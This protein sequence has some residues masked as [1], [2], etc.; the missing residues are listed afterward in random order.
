MNIDYKTIKY[1][2]LQTML[3]NGLDTSKLEQTFE[4]LI[5]NAHEDLSKNE[6]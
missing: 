1:N 5:M 4:N 2:L 6:V 3:E